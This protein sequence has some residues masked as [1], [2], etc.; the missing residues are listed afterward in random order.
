MMWARTKAEG[1]GKKGTDK[2]EV[3][4]KGK[5]E[6]IVNLLIFCVSSQSYLLHHILI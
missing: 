1:V 3:I 2:A 5:F 6:D 4:G